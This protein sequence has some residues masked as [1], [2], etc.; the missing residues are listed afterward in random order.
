MKE[1]KTDH[2]YKIYFYKPDKSI[3]NTYNFGEESFGHV[4]LDMKAVLVTT[5]LIGMYSNSVESVSE[6]INIPAKRGTSKVITITY[7]ESIQVFPCRDW[8]GILNVTVGGVRKRICT[9]RLRIEQYCNKLGLWLLQKDSVTY[10]PQWA[11]QS[12]H[13]NKYSQRVTYVTQ[14]VRKVT[15]HRV[16]LMQYCYMAT[17]TPSTDK[18][19]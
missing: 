14:Q 3:R 1:M 7:E 12:T 5:W 15:E 19:H 8:D 2:F 11:L 9:F 6:I 16:M 4:P 17:R 18:P 13:R 10:G